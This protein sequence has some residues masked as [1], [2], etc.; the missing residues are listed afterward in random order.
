V[1]TRLLPVPG[2]AAL[3]IAA[4]AITTNVSAAQAATPHF[5]SSQGQLVLR[6]HNA[7]GRVQSESVT[8]LAAASTVVC[9]AALENPHYSG[10]AESVIFKTRVTCSGNGLSIVQVRIRGTLGSICGAPPRG[11][12]A[13]GPLVLRATS[14]Q[15]QNV[16]VNGGFTTYYTP[17]AG[18]GNPKVRGS[19]WYQGDVSGKIVGPPGIVSDDPPRA[20]SNRVWVND[21]R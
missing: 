6:L 1:I 4:L 17:M 7:D 13:Q 9:D 16:T 19:G 20:F 11:G 3:F 5:R 12:P 18:P 14:D 21:P 2:T 15:I 10:G 8:P